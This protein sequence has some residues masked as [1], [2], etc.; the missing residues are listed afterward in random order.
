M[1]WIKA[2]RVESD[3]EAADGPLVTYI[4]PKQ[5]VVDLEEKKFLVMLVAPESRVIMYYCDELPAKVFDGIGDAF[6]MEHF[7]YTT[8]DE[9]AGGVRV[10]DKK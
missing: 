1:I 4:E 9:I 6:F 10:K 8:H 5:I 2:K 7:E 3:G